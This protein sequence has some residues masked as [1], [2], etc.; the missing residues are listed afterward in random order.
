MQLNIL[1]STTRTWAYPNLTIQFKIKPKQWSATLK[2]W[3]V[4]QKQET[5]ISNHISDLHCL[6]SR[7]PGLCQNILVHYWT[8]EWI[9]HL[10][11]IVSSVGSFVCW[12]QQ[13]SSKVYQQKFCASGKIKTNSKS[14]GI[15][16]SNP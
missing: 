2:L 9:F 12:Q 5:E 8:T 14:V 7:L 10:A 13:R 15:N 4:C 3:S 6:L 1:N 11:W 16:K